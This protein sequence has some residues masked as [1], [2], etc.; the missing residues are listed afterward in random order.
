MKRII[1]L[2]LVVILLSFGGCQKEIIEFN[3]NDKPPTA[4]PANSLFANS[5]KELTD[6]VSNINVNVNTFRLWSQHWT[7]TTYIDESNY[8]LTERNING[9][10]FDRMYARVLRDVKEARGF[11]NADGALSAGVKNAQLACLDIIQAYAYSIL[12]DVFGDVPFTEALMGVENLSPAYD[13]DAAIYASILADL[14][15]AVTTLK[16]STSMGDFGSSDILYGGSTG[17][18]AM[19]AAS[20]KLRLAMRMADVSGSGSQAMVESI[21]N[22]VFGSNS[23]HAV[24]N[25]QS[26]SPNTNPIWEDLVQSGRTDFIASNT[27]ADIMNASNDP[28]R[29]MY[30]RNLGAGDSIIGNPHGLGGA[31][32]D[33]SQPGDAL[34]VPTHAGVLLSFAEVQFHLADAANRGWA[35]PGAADV[36]YGYAVSASIMQWGGTQTDADA[37]LLEPSVQWSAAN[38]GELIGTQ[39]WV[40][41]YDQSLEAWSTWRMYDY[42]AMNV[43]AGAGTVPPFRYN[44]SVDE[45]SVNGTNVAAANGSNDALTGKVFWDVN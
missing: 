39:K 3:D 41:M 12:V 29:A 11:V 23:D 32:A 45:Y 35:T 14:T 31:Y 21:V 15:A 19:F 6:Y 38:A 24:L 27:L 36:H 40:A 17:H 18:W 33:Y 42:P 13:D 44:Y 16:S 4:V 25:Y 10:V 34:E 8:E 43:A 20:L 28:R 22:D 30:F 7:Q 9:E 2:S 37:F 1:N 5:I 26:A